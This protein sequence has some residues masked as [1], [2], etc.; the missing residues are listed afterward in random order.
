MTRASAAALHI[1]AGW[2]WAGLLGMALLA[3]GGC[4]SQQGNQGSSSVDNIVTP[5]DETEQRRRARIRL[6]LAVGYFEEGKTEIALDELKQVLAIDPNYSD[7]FVLRGL[8]FMRAG[9]NRA[10][11]EN[12]RRALAL[13]PRDA[14]AYHNLGWLQC[15]QGRYDESFRSFEQAMA[16][17]LYGERAKTLMSM[18]VCQARAGRNAEAEKTLARSYELDAGNPVTGYNLARLLYTRGDYERARF[19]IRRLNNSDLANSESLW[20]GIRVE[21]RLND[22][23]AMQQL[24]DQLRRRFPQSKEKA[25]FDRGAFDE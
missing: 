25:A 15:N 9:D 21:R 14:N 13:N 10:S 22:R 3:L 11:E 8:I 1:R 17:P 19:Y 18:G 12:F 23:V 16:S 24:A 4:A 2:A 5:S 20:L 7:A 6:E